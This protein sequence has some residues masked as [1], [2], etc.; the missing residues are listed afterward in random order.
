MPVA[1]SGWSQVSLQYRAGGNLVGDLHRD[2]PVIA[3][4]D[5]NTAARAPESVLGRR[6]HGGIELL[7]KVLTVC[8]GRCWSSRARSCFPFWCDWR[9]RR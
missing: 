8:D 7:F 2:V 4:G 5:E 9:I 1:E 6:G 3:A